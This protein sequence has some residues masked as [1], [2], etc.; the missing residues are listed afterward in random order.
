MLEGSYWEQYQ[1]ANVIVLSSFAGLPHSSIEI[2]ATCLRDA[3]RRPSPVDVYERTA[4]QGWHLRNS[5]D[6]Y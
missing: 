3:P 6:F 1:Y 4:S 2:R 5:L